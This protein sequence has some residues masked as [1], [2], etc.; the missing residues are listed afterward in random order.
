MIISILRQNIT[1]AS[2]STMANT[3]LQ[4]YP[5]NTYFLRSA[6]FLAPK[7]WAT[8]ITNPLQTPIQKPIIMKLIEPVAPTPARA[9][10]PR[11]LPTI[12]VSTRL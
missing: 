2:V 7:H 1:D 6:G 8:G 4:I 9:S 10:T 3:I 12:I 11:V 5:L